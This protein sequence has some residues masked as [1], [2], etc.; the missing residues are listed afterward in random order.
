M[1]EQGTS[2]YA[3]GWHGF[4]SCPLYCRFPPCLSP[5]ILECDDASR[6]T[7]RE[8]GDRGACGHWRQCALV[9]IVETIVGPTHAH[10][11]DGMDVMALVCCNM[12]PRQSQRSRA[13]VLCECGCLTLDRA[14]GALCRWCGLH[15]WIC[16]FFRVADLICSIMPPAG[17]LGRGGALTLPLPAAFPTDKAKYTKGPNLM[18]SCGDSAQI[19]RI[20][21]ASVEKGTALGCV[22]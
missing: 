1:S 4:R 11:W 22:P 10:W 13:K 14:G 12:A 7:Q 20:F 2:L 8:L 19:F 5:G 15:S 18:N 21:R 16:L 6:L 3:V 9:S 17:A